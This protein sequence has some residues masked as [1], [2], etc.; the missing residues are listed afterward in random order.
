MIKYKL[1]IIQE[2]EKTREVVVEGTYL[3][4]LMMIEA[5]REFVRKN[6]K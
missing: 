5:V 1:Q 6:R 2:T 3:D 4:P